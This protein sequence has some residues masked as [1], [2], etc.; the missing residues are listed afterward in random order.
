MPANVRRLGHVPTG[1]HNR[2]NSSVRAVLNISRNDMADLGF[3]PA[4]RVFEAA[5]AGACL[6]TDQWPGIEMFLQPGLEILVAKD[7][8]AVLD[9]L[10]QLTPSSARRIGGKARL[11]MLNGHTYRQR[12][13]EVGVALTG[14]RRPVRHSPRK[15][16]S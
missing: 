11:R 2:L 5:G 8:Q 14:L 12:A 16:A 7:G 9:H 3:A 1:L 4:T 15:P 6:I 13:L 10:R